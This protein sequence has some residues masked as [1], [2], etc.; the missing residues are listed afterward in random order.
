LYNPSPVSTG[1]Y[2]LRIKTK[3]TAGNEARWQTLFI[4]KHDGTPVCPAKLQSTCR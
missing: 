1:I 4:F 2:Y 3:D